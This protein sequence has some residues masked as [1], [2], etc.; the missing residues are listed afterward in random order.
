MISLSVKSDV[1]KLTRHLTKIQKKQVPFATA[2]AL[3]WT[4][5]EIQKG[6]ANDI[7]KIFKTTRK[8]WMPRQPTGIKIKPAKKD[9]LRAIVYSIAYF[10]HL[11]E[12]GGIKIPFR[13]RGILVPTP[14]TP[15][16]GR[17][18][19][20]A[21]KVMAG[22]KILRAAGKASGAPVV[23]APSGTKG[24]FRRK[25]KARLPIERL[26][27]YTPTAHILPRLGF[28]RRAAHKARQRFRANFEKSLAMA[29]KSA[30]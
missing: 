3:T 29:L 17:K 9:N 16:Y 19:G 28:R 7:P 10:L 15:K 5:K 23:R 18:A 21:Q 20:G 22:K 27:A 11:Q 1:K 6:I 2:R 13:G 26:Y 14:L 24:V 12:F 4:V 8:W 25:G 30:R